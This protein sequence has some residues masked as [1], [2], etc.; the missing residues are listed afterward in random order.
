MSQKQEFSLRVKLNR[1]LQ[2]IQTRVNRLSTLAA[3]G[4]VVLISSLLLTT[5]SSG[6]DMCHLRELD[7]CIVGAASLLQNPNGLPISQAEIERQCEYMQ[8]STD[9]FSNYASKCMTE[10]Q[11]ML[12]AWF[13]S[14]FMQVQKD[15]CSNETAI[16][17]DYVKKATCLRE[18]QRKHQ[19]A[20][21]S[22]LQAG[23]ASL[24]KLNRTTRWP[25]SC[26]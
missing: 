7:I 11:G 17:Q 3:V 24:H 22:D 15:M 12:L 9:C 25:T 21:A 26:W 6:S 2:S 20:C 8:E 4:L 5:S 1:K 19:R 16:R 13:S 23:F 18:V 14:D 10:R